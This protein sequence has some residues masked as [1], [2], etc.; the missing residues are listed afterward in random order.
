MTEIKEPIIQNKEEFQSIL[1]MY[2][3]IRKKSKERATKYANE[4]EMY[5]YKGEM[6]VVFEIVMQ[7]PLDDING[8]LENMDLPILSMKGE[9]PITIG[10]SNL[11][12]L[13]MTSDLEDKVLNKSNN[14]IGKIT[15]VEIL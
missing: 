10:V 14:K 5:L 4:H 15:K 7:S 6:K 1:D 13:D 3:Y 11:V 12:A 2:L 8:I 9:Y